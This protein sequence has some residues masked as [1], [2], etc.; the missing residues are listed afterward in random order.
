MEEEKLKKEVAENMLN[1]YAID[2]KK[3]EL[4]DNTIGK[5]VADIKQWLEASAECIEKTDMLLYKEKLCKSYKMTSVNSKIISI[6]RYLKWLGHKELIVKTQR[7]QQ[8]NGLEHMITKEYYFKMLD[9]AKIHNKDKIFYIMKTIAQTGIRIGELKFVTVEAIKQG[10]TVVWNKGKHRTIYFNDRLCQELLKYC[11]ECEVES[12]IIF[13]GREF[14]KSI[15]PGAVWKS[16]KYIAKEAGVPEIMVYPH[17]F[18]HLFAKEYMRKIGD[19]SELA[20]L[21]GHSRLETT[22]IYTK[23][24]SDEKREKLK[25]LDL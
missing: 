4:S 3:E 14:D 11:T 7:I 24:T 2:M 9:Y 5:Y 18:R 20:D 23:T 21:L 15:T 6:N 19:I 16:L 1:K 17:S 12:G 13:C 8:K 25:Q 22:W 10:M